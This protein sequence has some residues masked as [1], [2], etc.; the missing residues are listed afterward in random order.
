MTRYPGRRNYHT[1]MEISNTVIYKRYTVNKVVYHWC[2]RY[3]RVKKATEE[4]NTI[5]PPTTA[6]ARLARLIPV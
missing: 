5:I 1:Q 3:T 2:L 4:L 6:S